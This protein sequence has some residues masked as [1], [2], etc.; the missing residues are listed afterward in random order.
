MQ[1]ISTGRRG[2]YGSN[3]DHS[4]SQG[5]KQKGNRKSHHGDHSSHKTASATPSSSV[6]VAN[7]EE[8]PGSNTSNVE[9]SAPAGGSEAGVKHVPGNGGSSER[10]RGN[11]WRGQDNVGYGGGPRRN[12]RDNVRSSNHGWNQRGFRMN[13]GP[14]VT[15][16]TGSNRN[17]SNR[18]MFNNN[19]MSEFGNP[20]GLIHVPVR[21][22]FWFLSVSASLY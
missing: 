1:T 3:S 10:S 12:G 16:R 20:A 9:P 19:N 21:L 6:D 8:G 18:N 7:P 4:T 5:I 13:N 15:L 17:Y 11:Y 22:R 2:P 14:A